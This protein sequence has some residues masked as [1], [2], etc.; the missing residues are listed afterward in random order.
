MNQK[1]KQCGSCR[2]FHNA[3]RTLCKRYPPVSIDNRH[4]RYP[5]VFWDD[6]CGEWVSTNE[7]IPENNPFTE[8]TD[9]RGQQK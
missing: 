9:R 3:A 8:S 4:A 6:W 2:H 1:L 5:A 7:N